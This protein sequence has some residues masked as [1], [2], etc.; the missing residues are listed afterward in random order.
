MPQFPDIAFVELLDQANLNSG[1]ICVWI[2]LHV[3]A[4]L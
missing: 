4:D 3:E 1:R 2:F